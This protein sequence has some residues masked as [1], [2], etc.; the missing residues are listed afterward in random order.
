ML[1]THR[2][3]AGVMA[4]NVT[5]SR[6]LRGKTEILPSLLLTAFLHPQKNALSLWRHRCK[7]KV[8]VGMKDLGEKVAGK[9]SHIWALYA[10]PQRV[11]SG[12][13]S[14]MRWWS[15]Q[16]RTCQ[17]CLGATLLDQ[18][19]QVFWAET[20]SNV[21]SGMQHTSRLMQI[22]SRYTDGRKGEGG[23]DSIGLMKVKLTLSMSYVG[24]GFLVGSVESS[25]SAEEEGEG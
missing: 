3:H 11:M 9:W 20:D 5:F 2:W 4:L 17:P 7:W 25:G 12:C 24:V 6:D 1:P 13:G 8:A 21:E 14:E 18:R 23:V 10:A 22:W 16:T 19:S 15:G